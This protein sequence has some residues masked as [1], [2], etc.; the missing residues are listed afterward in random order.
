MCDIFGRPKSSFRCVIII[1]TMFSSWWGVHMSSVMR[2]FVAGGHFPIFSLTPLK[3]ILTDQNSRVV[4]LVIDILT[5][6]LIFCI[7][8][9][10]SWLF[11][12]NFI[13][14]EFYHSIPIRDILFFFN[15]VLVLSIV[16]LSFS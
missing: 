10:Y 16:F 5:S 14:F 11:C 4:L 3:I 1:F 15:M 8:N 7:F 12:E 2:R 6:V 9:F 13:C